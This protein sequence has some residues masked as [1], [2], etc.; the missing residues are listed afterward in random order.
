MIVALYAFV[1]QLPLSVQ[2][3]V[4]FFPHLEISPIA[5]ADAATTNSDRIEVIKLAMADAP[6]YWLTGR[7]FGMDRFDRMPVDDP[8]DS[9][10]ILYSQGMFYNGFIGTLL[11]LGLPGL[12]CSLVFMWHV[13]RMAL[14]LVRSVTRRSS[15]EWRVFDRLCLLLCAQWFS[16]VLL[17]YLT[18]GDVTWWMQ[19]FGLPA[20]LIMACRRVQLEDAD[21]PQMETAK[22]V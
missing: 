17:F 19:Y 8:N 21:E 3:S 5:K 1:D 6:K 16:A 18:N 4:S 7:G 9:V 11:K 10:G 22:G 12:L 13:S 20:G 15:R 2:R 14:E